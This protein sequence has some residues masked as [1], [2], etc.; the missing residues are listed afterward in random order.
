MTIGFDLFDSKLFADYLANKRGLVES[1]VHTYIGVIEQ[2]L[3]EAENIEDLESYNSFIVKYGIKKRCAYYYNV[4]RAFIDW[5]FTDQAVKDN[6]LEHLVRPQHRSD[7][8][9]ER[10]NLSEEKILDVINSLN[11]ANHKIIALI[12]SLTGVRAGDIMKLK[13]GG[14]MPEEYEGKP[15]LRLNILGKGQKRNVV[16]I[17]DEIAQAV[18]L[19]YIENNPSTNG[20]LFLNDP[21]RNLKLFRSDYVLYKI[22]YNRYWVD[23][24]EALQTNGVNQKD[25]ATH[26]FRRCFARRVW[27]RFKDVNVLQ[28]MLNHA[29]ADTSL[30]YLNQ[31]GLQNIEYSKEMQK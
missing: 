10:K 7:L 6:M 4:L 24:K 11:G 1:S 2:F 15:V 27:S 19:D 12:Q 3:I 16:Y 9:Y 26:D 30:R 5:K 20:F 17:H 25:F 22:N 29:R 18:V 28:K 8:K 13:V 31:S 23:L 21:I 14:L